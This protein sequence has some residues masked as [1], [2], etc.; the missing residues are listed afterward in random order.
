M[1]LTATEAMWRR[2]HA[3]H[4]SG[5]GRYP[6]TDAVYNIRQRAFDLT[7]SD[8]H[9]GDGFGGADVFLDFIAGTVRP[10]VKSTLFPS[11]EIDREG[12][13]GHLYGGLF[14]LHALFTHP[15][16]FS[17]FMAASPSI[18]WSN[19][20]ILKEEEQYR[21]VGAA[22]E[23]KPTLMMY[24]GSYEKNPQLWPGE[25]PENF[26]KRQA[27]AQDRSMSGYARSMYERLSQ[28][29]KLH[30]IAL[31]EYPQEDHGSVVGCVLSRSLTTFFEEWPFLGA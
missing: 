2:A 17:G 3:P 27:A 23:Q 28:S 29:N 24:F 13:F 4:S 6:L 9:G 18:Y 11:V 30:A 25:S 5:G 15:Q 20:F 22:Q 10:F 19:A 26:K 14:V 16:L 12:I 31:Q 1:F 21:E 8:A 7:P